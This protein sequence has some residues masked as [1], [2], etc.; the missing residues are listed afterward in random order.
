MNLKRLCAYKTATGLVMHNHPN[1]P[2]DSESTQ[3]FSHLLAVSGHRE[4][5]GGGCAVQRDGQSG[6]KCHTGGFTESRPKS[7]PIRL[8]SHATHNPG[9]DSSF[10]LLH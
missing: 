8:K 9:P 1:I 2:L 10:H 7:G 4:I 3:M 5:G 6:Q